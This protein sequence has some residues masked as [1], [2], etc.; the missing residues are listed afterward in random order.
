[1]AEMVYLVLQGLVFCFWLWSMGRHERTMRGL[2]AEY[3]A[4]VEKWVQK[5]DEV[6]AQNQ[7]TEAFVEQ[8]LRPFLEMVE[9]RNE[10]LLALRDASRRRPKDVS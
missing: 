1:M 9:K 6:C 8:Q 3:A 7:R 4:L 2:N 5:L 10:S